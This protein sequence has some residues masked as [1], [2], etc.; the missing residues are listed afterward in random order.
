[1][2]NSNAVDYPG[3]IS[4]KKSH[5]RPQPALSQGASYTLNVS[6]SRQQPHDRRLHRYHWGFPSSGNDIVLAD[7][8][9]VEVLPGLR[10]LCDLPHSVCTGLKN[11]GRIDS[12]IPGTPSPCIRA[13]RGD[14][15]RGFISGA[16]YR[17][18]LAPA[19]LPA[20]PICFFEQ[21]W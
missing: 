11:R 6:D 9:S 4:V 3:L 2:A 10:Q 18:W 15:D 13:P 19:S 7:R 17:Q 14:Q 8:T 5:R 16:T 20:L 1:M 12:P 21:P